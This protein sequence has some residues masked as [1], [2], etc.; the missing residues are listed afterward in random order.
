VFPVLVLL[1]WFTFVRM[2]QTSVEAMLCLTRIQR[3]RSY[4]VRLAPDE[5]WF[6]DV[7]AGTPPS[8]D[9]AAGAAHPIVPCPE[10]GS[11]RP[12]WA[13]DRLRGSTR[14]PDVDPAG[15]QKPTVAAWTACNHAR[16]FCVLLAC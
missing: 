1:G 6:A 4:D 12:H 9:D 16:R 3:I 15:V 10:G 13:P 14:P 5:A 11:R 7:R 8:G 2:V